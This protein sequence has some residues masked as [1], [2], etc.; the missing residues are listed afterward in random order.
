[1]IACLPFDAPLRAELETRGRKDFLSHFFTQYVQP[2]YVRNFPDARAESAKYLPSILDGSLL[3][4]NLLPNGTAFADRLHL[5]ED[6]PDPVAKHG[7]ILFIKNDRI[8]IV[9]TELYERILFHGSFQKTT[10][11]EDSILRTRLMRILGKMSFPAADAS[12]SSAIAPAA[13]APVTAPASAS[14][15]SAPVPPTAR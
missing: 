15:A 2:E 9:T 12:A 1:M 13:S 10:E 3:V 4:M 5:P 11:E 6:A 8:F 7:S 14:G